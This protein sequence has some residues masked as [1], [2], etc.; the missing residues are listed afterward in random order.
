MIA[1]ESMPSDVE[2][3]VVVENG[4]RGFEQPLAQQDDELLL[5]CGQWRNGSD[6]HGWEPQRLDSRTACVKLPDR[7]VNLSQKGGFRKQTVCPPPGGGL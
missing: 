5:E 7:A 6:G 4:S 1:M 2:I 3:G